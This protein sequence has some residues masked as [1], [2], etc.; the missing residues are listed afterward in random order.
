MNV[1]QIEGTIMLVAALALLAVKIF[2]L[3][4]SLM[5][6]PEHYRAADKL[7]KPAWVAI[8]GLGVAANLLFVGNPMNLINLAFTIAALVYLADVRPAL[9]GLRQR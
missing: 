6:T 3:V 8:L 1:F 9:S 7:T 5:F 4:T 2:A